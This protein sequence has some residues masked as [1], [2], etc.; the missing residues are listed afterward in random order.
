MK[1]CCD[2]IQ[3]AIEDAHMFPPN[4]EEKEWS[5]TL[6]CDW[7]VE[8]VDFIIYCCPFCGHNLAREVEDWILWREGLS[9]DDDY[10]P[11][12]QKDKKREKPPHQKEKK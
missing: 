6:T 9:K 4:D 7:Q 3:K 8:G 12:R 2:A 5:M 1:Y 10:L 11:P